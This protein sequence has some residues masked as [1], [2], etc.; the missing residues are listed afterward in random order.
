MELER[1][2][3]LIAKYGD[4]SPKKNKH[5]VIYWSNRINNEQIK[6]ENKRWTTFKQA[7]Q[8]YYRFLESISEVENQI[9]YISFED[10]YRERLS[11]M[12]LKNK[13]ST[14]KYN[15]LMNKK[16]ILPVFGNL[17]I[18]DIDLKIIHEFQHKLIKST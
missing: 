13:I 10:V 8:D 16:H 14:V 7:K 12:K 6:R 18:R 2:G 9:D 4:V 11:L 5:G 3:Y 15:E 17:P 1:I